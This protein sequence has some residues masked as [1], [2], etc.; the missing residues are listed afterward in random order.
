MGALRRRAPTPRPRPASAVHFRFHFGSVH[1]HWITKSAGGIPVLNLSSRS[2]ASHFF[3]CHGGCLGGGRNCLWVG[4]RRGF[5]HRNSPRW[6]R[7]VFGGVGGGA[8]VGGLAGGLPGVVAGE[9]PSLV[10][11]WCCPGGYWCCPGGYWC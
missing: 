9:A 11:Y 10:G 6:D 5:L 1:A 4:I 3:G 2:F 7:G 8:G